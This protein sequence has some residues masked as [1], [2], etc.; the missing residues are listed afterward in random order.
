[1]VRRVGWWV[2]DMLKSE[3]PGPNG[4]STPSAD[5]I[6]IQTRAGSRSTSTRWWGRRTKWTRTSS[7]WLPEESGCDGAY[8]RW[9]AGWLAGVGCVILIQLTPLPHRT[10]TPHTY[11]IQSKVAAVFA[12]AAELLVGRVQGPAGVRGLPPRRLWRSGTKR[13]RFVS[14]YVTTRVKGLV[15]TQMK[16]PK[17]TTNTQETS[18]RP[19]KLPLA[20]AH[21]GTP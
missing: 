15:G 17:L 6:Q 2:D 18:N 1:M 13:V 8:H 7:L 3:A 14:P 21:R 19:S 16:R 20:L 9:L 4:S 12:G 11:P 10:T 5:P